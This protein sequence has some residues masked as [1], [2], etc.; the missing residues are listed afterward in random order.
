VNKNCT[1]TLKKLKPGLTKK[2]ERKKKE[3]MDAG[4]DDRPI[5]GAKKF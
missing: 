2:M 4:C 1:L 3:L 5:K